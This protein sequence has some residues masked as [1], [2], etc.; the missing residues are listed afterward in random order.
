MLK[1]V[2]SQ[3]EIKKKHKTVSEICNENIVTFKMQCKHEN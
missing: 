3:I 1:L 2:L